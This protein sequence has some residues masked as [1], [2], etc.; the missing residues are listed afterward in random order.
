MTTFRKEQKWPF[1]PTP[2]VVGVCNDSTLAFMVL[3]AQFSLIWYATWLLSVKDIVWPFDPT[4]WVKGVSV[5][6][7]FA[8]MLLPASSALIWYAT[9]LLSEKYIVWPFD[10]T[11]W[12]EGLS[13]GKIFAT[14]L[15]PASS[16]LIWYA[17]WPY[18]EKVEFW[19]Q[20]HPP[21]PPKGFG[22]RPSNWNP[23]WYVSYLLLL[24]LH[25]K[26]QQK[27]LIIALVIAKFKYLTFDPL[28][29]VKGGGVK[30]WHFPSYLQALGNHG[31]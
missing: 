15:L 22:I 2:G 11:P 26:F 23:V 27:I 14:M 19:P 16:A 18:S 12:T 30:L 29:G 4:P 5:G 24:C 28:G 1:D 20:P 8:T 7:I 25:A 21:S 31:L 9:W 17:T 6:K 10:P 13:V 3:C